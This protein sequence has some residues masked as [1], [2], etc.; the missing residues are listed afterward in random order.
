MNVRNPQIVLEQ[1]DLELIALYA[2]GD[3]LEEIG[4]AKYLSYRGVQNVLTKAREKV[5]AK[6]LTHLC[7]VCMDYGVIYRNG[8]GYKPVIDE[9]VVG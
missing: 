5:G 9:R 3:T 6:N 4:T 8:T 2:S 1:R 7:V